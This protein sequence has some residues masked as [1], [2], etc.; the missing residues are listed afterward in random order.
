ME[1]TTTDK[2]NE[3]YKI[4]NPKTISCKKPVEKSF[5]CNHSENYWHLAQTNIFLNS[6]QNL[7]NCLPVTIP[8]SVKGK[9]NT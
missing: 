7:E 6:F 5:H 9:V 8:S 2:I 3:C 4:P 1:Q